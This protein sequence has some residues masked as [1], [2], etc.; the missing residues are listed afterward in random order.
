METLAVTKA[1]RWSVTLGRFL[2]LYTLCSLTWFASALGLGVNVF[3]L[4]VLT[5]AALPEES[6]GPSWSPDWLLFGAL[7]LAFGATLLVS[8]SL[9]AMLSS[10]AKKREIAAP[11]ASIVMVLG[12][13]AIFAAN[14]TDGPPPDWVPFVPYSSTVHLILRAS[15]GNWDGG[16]VTQVSLV[17]ILFAI[18]S[19]IGLFWA[20]GRQRQLQGSFSQPS[21]R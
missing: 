10:I 18:P 19:L 8:T 3:H 9:A 11:L 12:M 2:A 16:L 5:E 21:H 7:G 17:H 6:S 1:P 14:E 15:E 13:V 20:Q 4:K